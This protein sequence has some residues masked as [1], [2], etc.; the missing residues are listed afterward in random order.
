MQVRF[1][2]RLPCYIKMSKR[3]LVLDNLSSVIEKIR[4]TGTVYHAASMLGIK[5]ATLTKYLK[6]AKVDYSKMLKPLFGGKS[7]T[8][9]VPIEDYL[10]GKKGI[11]A[12]SLRIKLIASGLK[13]N[14]CEICG[15][16]KWMNKPIPLELHHKNGDHSDNRLEN[17]QIA[18]SNCHMQAHGYSNVSCMSTR[19]TTSRTSRTHVLRS[20]RRAAHTQK[21]VD[22][23]RVI[24][25]TATRCKECDR[26][27]RIARNTRFSPEEIILEVQKRGSFLK[28]AKR[29]CVTANAL[30][31][32]LRKRGYPYHTKDV[33]AFN[34]SPSQPSTT[35]VQLTC[36]EQVT[37]SNPVA[38]SMHP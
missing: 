10:S 37:G 27:F 24:G 21:C 23:G 26:K 25:Y 20:P 3:K 33:K 1:L 16:S 31:K 11:C 30:I 36:N 12:A 29:F 5:H 28:A 34:V 18:C 6:E 13:E 4:E 8:R 35:V 14:K 19:S 9:N 2:S 15:R 32:F 7:C 38:G 17:L 22:C